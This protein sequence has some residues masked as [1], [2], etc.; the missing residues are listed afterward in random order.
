MY[1]YLNIYAAFA[2]L[3]ILNSWI[4]NFSRPVMNKANKLGQQTRTSGVKLLKIS[5]KILQ[6]RWSTIM[7]SKT[8][9]L[10]A[11]RFNTC[12]PL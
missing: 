7:I 2:L 11:I 9:R 1:A 6:L 5:P 10:M 8:V 3:Y 12:V 4:F